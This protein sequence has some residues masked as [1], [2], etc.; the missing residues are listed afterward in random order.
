MPIASPTGSSLP[1]ERPG[2][3]CLRMRE[4]FHFVA[5]KPYLTKVPPMVYTRRTPVT[6]IRE[7]RTW[8]LYKLEHLYNAH[9]SNAVTDS[10]ITPTFFNY[11]F[12]TPTFFNYSI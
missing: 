8:E 11:S 3:H 2:T 9:G 12:I 10:F 4:I 7:V 1:E 5:L 6:T